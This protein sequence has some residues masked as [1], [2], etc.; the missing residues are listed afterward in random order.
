MYCFSSQNAAD[1]YCCSPANS[2]SEPGQYTRPCPF[3]SSSNGGAATVCTPASKW[4][5]VVLEPS[6]TI[7][8]S[9]FCSCRCFDVTL[10]VFEAG[11]GVQ[12]APSNRG[13]AARPLSVGVQE[14]Q[15]MFVCFCLQTQVFSSFGEEKLCSFS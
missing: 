9:E 3:R 4:H 14:V 12:L 11:S 2:S 6:T 13:D 8:R 1:G 15:E 10:Y 7:S 5:R